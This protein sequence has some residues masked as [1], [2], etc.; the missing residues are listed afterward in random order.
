VGSGLGLE[1]LPAVYSPLHLL[2]SSS[3]HIICLLQQHHNTAAYKGVLLLHALL[4]RIPPAQL[5]TDTLVTTAPQHS[6]LQGGPAPTNTACSARYWYSGFNNITTQHSGVLLIYALIQCTLHA[7]K[8][9]VLDSE[10]SFWIR[11]CIRPYWQ[12]IGQFLNFFGQIHCWFYTYSLRKALKGVQGLD[13]TLTSS[14]K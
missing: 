5:G 10:K 2:T 14:S 7:Q 13:A 3:R 9:S 8:G 6:S 1:E 4:Q 12:K 11:E